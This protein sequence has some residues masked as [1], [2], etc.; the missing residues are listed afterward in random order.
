M[1]SFHYVI[2]GVLVIE[3]FGEILVHLV[4]PVVDEVSH[5]TQ[6]GAECIRLLCVLCSCHVGCILYCSSSLL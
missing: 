2:E 5:I 4:E 1:S 3:D 6:L